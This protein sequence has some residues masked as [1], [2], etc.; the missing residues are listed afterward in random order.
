MEYCPGDN[1]SDYIRQKGPLFSYNIK[2]IFKQIVLAVN[3]LHNN[4]IV[5]RDLKPENILI[6][7]FPEVKVSDFDLCERYD[8]NQKIDSFCGTTQYTAP[9]CL[10][11]IPYDGAKSDIWSL[12]VLLY[13]LVFGRIPW[14]GT[15]KNSIVRQIL[16]GHI[17]Y[18]GSV[19]PSTLS[20]LKSILQINPK[21]RPS[22]E[23]ILQHDFMVYKELSRAFK[24]NSAVS[25]IKARNQP[26][27]IV[28]PQMKNK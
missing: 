28:V 6:T 1:L 22:C 13:F 4:G 8:P 25:T 11:G 20:L 3:H 5:H 24:V 10:C 27:K 23:K 14:D 19:N 15:D 26:A 18:P 17:F 2:H 21:N 7:T 12:G 9:E 16:S